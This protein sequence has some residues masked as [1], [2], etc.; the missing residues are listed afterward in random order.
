MAIKPENIQDTFHI[1]D[2]D[3]KKKR[4]MQYILQEHS[5][6]GEQPMCKR[7]D[8]MSHKNTLKNGEVSAS[9][10]CNLKD[11]APSVFKLL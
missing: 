10:L 6:F 11:T 2:T 8:I 7:E 9:D 4:K 3:V 1:Q 5:L